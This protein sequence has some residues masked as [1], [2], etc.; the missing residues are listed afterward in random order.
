MLCCFDGFGDPSKAYN[1]QTNDGG[2]SSFPGQRRYHATGG[3]ALSAA[4]PQS[5]FPPQQSSFP[6]QAQHSSGGDMIAGKNGLSHGV[7]L[8][9]QDHTTVLTVSISTF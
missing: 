4:P 2:V 6:S 7:V 9:F 5:S 8:Y 1:R 3:N